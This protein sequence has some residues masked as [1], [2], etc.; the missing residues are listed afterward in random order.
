VALTVL[1]KKHNVDGRTESSI[2][3]IAAAKVIHLIADQSDLL[4]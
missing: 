1:L 4:L 2:S 3:N